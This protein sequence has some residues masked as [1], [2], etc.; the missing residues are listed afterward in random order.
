MTTVEYDVRFLHHSCCVSLGSL[1]KKVEEERSSAREE[2]DH[3]CW[4]EANDRKRT[5]TDIYRFTSHILLCVEYKS[6]CSEFD[7]HYRW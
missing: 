1:R 4:D 3:E 6:P 5:T 7:E 2:D